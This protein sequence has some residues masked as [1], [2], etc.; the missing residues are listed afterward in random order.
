MLVT[1][2]TILS[3]TATLAAASPTGLSARADD[4]VEVTFCA[5]PRNTATCYTSNP[6]LLKCYDIKKNANIMTI[7]DVDVQCLYSSDPCHDGDGDNI[8][9]C[10][11]RFRNCKRFVTSSELGPDARSFK[12]SKKHA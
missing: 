8:P 10:G 4:T 9:G 12:C 6:Q 5:D 2:T 1:L 11:V 7:H 3:L